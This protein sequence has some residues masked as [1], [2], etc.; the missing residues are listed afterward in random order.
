MTKLFRSVFAPLALSFSVL[1]AA[2][3]A[4]AG[5]QKGEKHQKAP[6]ASIDGKFDRWLLSPNGKIDGMLLDG[7]RVVRL[8]DG[9]VKDSSLKS[10]DALHVDAK[11]KGTTYHRAKVT[12]NGVVVVDDTAKQDKGKHQKPDL[13]KLTD[14][15]GSGKVVAVLKGHGGKI[16]GVVLE[17]GTTAYA[18][19]KADLGSFN[20]KVGDSVT[21]TGK[22]GAYAL[23][24]SLIIDSIKLPNGDTKK[25]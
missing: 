16:H 10:G 14:V 12:K 22:G 25:L 2:A 21:V 23:G 6:A 8:S 24:R 9:S 1:V 15:S 19:H 17:G 7:G 3:P 20:L 5:D 18:R 13:S 11:G 4:F